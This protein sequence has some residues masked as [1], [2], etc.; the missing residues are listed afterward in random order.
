[1]TT[2]NVHKRPLPNKL[3]AR[4][5]RSVDCLEGVFGFVVLISE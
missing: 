1:M 2:F 5:G 3:V 4:Y